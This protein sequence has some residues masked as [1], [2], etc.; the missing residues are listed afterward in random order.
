[1]KILISGGAGYIGSITARN[2]A[3]R[4]HDILIVDNLSLGHRQSVGNLDISVTDIDDRQALLDVCN[5]FQPE[6]A[7]HF[8]A[9]SLV[10]ESM[11][12]P[13]GYLGGNIGG[14]L[15]LFRAMVES[16]GKY[17]V[18]SSSA[19]VYGS[20]AEIPIKEDALISPINP[21]GASKVICEQCLQQLSEY[22]QLK[23]VSLRYFNAAG[24]DTANDLGEDHSPETHLIP[25]VISAAL[26][27]APSVSIFGTDYKT[28]DGTC[29]RDYIHVNDLANAHRIALDY[30]S[31]GGESGI[32]NLGN[33]NGFSVREIV[34]VV[35]SISGTDFDVIEED[36]RPGDPPVLVAS[37]R[38]AEA[39]LGWKPEHADIDG[40][41]RS[42]W[43]WHSK[44]P[45]G[46][47]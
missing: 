23:F 43:E 6:A 1:M 16:G 27:K 29:V 44:H 17:V 22:N 2:L 24:A 11:S 13:L 33:A 46:Y 3:D 34:D 5:G 4:G 14:S 45:D 10:G 15:N 32:F 7:V 37:N 28:P 25:R 8:A 36:R 30:M 19:A 39:E 12:N 9:R 47:R 26:G 21:Y 41:V 40:I 31:A 42:A 35:K 38:R 18:F 20:P